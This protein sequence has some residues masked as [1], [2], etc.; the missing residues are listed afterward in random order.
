MNTMAERTHSDLE[1]ALPSS[2]AG[3]SSGLE[4]EPDDTYKEVQSQPNPPQEV[5]AYKS[6]NVPFSKS[7]GESPT[8]NQPRE[9]LCGLAPKT[10]YIIAAII[11]VVL[12][13]AAVGG[14][15]GGSQ[16]SKKSTASTSNSQTTTSSGS[17]NSIQGTITSA[18]SATTHP[19][20][21][22]STVGPSTTLTVDCPSSNDTI[23]N[24]NGALFQKICSDAPYNALNGLDVIN[25]QSH[26]LDDCI[27]ACAGY[28]LVNQT[29][30]RA[31]Q[32][33]VCNAVCWR[34]TIQGDDFPGQCFGYTTQN[35]TGSFKLSGDTR[36]NSA[37]WINQSL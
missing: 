16:A 36:C 32:N 19:I 27:N 33:N 8:T 2:T 21:T 6:D 25:E 30:I 5:Y 7:H 37:A 31:G 18:P 1:A 28:N 15:V 29:A 12:V 3:V 13:A 34:A 20:T 9:R 10:F 35:S 22:T 14:G 26:T 17:S 11:I 24:A 4:V 23:Y